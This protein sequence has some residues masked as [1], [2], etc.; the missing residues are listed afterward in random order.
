[1]NEIIQK[2]KR[3][4]FNSLV[5][6]IS[7][8]VTLILFISLAVF[9]FVFVVS[10]RSEILKD[11]VKNGEVFAH[12]TVEKIYGDYAQYYIHPLPEDFETFKQLTQT[13]LNNNKDV[14]GVNLIAFNGRILFDSGE[15]ITGKATSSERKV[16]DSQLLQ[17]LAS[18]TVSSREIY[19][20]NEWVTEI[21]VPLTEVGGGHILSMR[22]LVS[23]TSLNERMNEIYKQI[24]LTVIPLMVLIILVVVFFTVPLIRPIRGLTQAVE[25]IRGGDLNVKIDTKS[26]DEIGQLAVNFNEMSEELKKLYET[27]EEKVR[28]RTRELENK[29]QEL[30]KLNKELEGLKLKTEFLQIIN[31]QLRTPISAIR[32]YLDFWKTGV[33]EK[34]PPQ[35]QEEIK[36]NIISASEQLAIIVNNMIE[37]LQLEAD[38]SVAK[39]DISDIDIKGLIEEIYKVDFEKKCIEKKLFFKL[40]AQDV[41]TIQSDRKYLTAIISNLLDNAFKYTLQGGVEI[42]IVRDNTTIEIRVK[43]SGI[44]LNEEDKLKLFQKFVRSKTAIKISPTGSG[45][46]L[47]IVKKMTDILHGKINVMSNGTDQ[48]ATF[49]IKLP[50]HHEKN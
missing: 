32:G 40:N 39:L 36:G 5:F 12:S 14:I 29:N 42:T 46:G 30:N 49:I 6:K 44:G 37:A 16:Q 25:K 8:F 4:I 23:N 33:Y 3:F 19:Q 27:L 22:Y 38:G 10:E 43:D 50:I 17:I 21:V 18:D 48:G 31:H 13:T 1:M 24:A 41:G 11:I 26:K 45:L 2:P 15:F 47:Y 28:M 20:N 9:S 34:F 35:K 7:F